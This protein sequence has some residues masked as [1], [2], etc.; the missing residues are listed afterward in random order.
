M[1]NSLASVLLTR[2]Q[3]SARL[4]ELRARDVWSLGAMALLIA[5]VELIGRASATEFWDL[6]MAVLL[7]S[8]LAACIELHRKCGLRWTRPVAAALS[9]GLRRLRVFEFEFGI[10]LRGRPPVPPAVPPALL[11]LPTTLVTLAAGALAWIAWG[12]VPF[13]AVAVQVSYVGYVAVMA[14]LWSAIVI[15]ALRMAVLPVLL[16]FDMLIVY[17]GLSRRQARPWAST[18]AALY[19][20]TLLVCGLMLPMWVGTLL[21]VLAIPLGLLLTWSPPWRR[22]ICLWKSPSSAVRS[23]SGRTFSTLT[24]VLCIPLALLVLVLFSLGGAALGLAESSGESWAMQFWFAPVSTALGAGGLWVFAPGAVLTYLLSGNH[25]LIAR[26]HDPEAPAPTTLHVQGPRDRA[27][28]V[29]IVQHVRSRGWQVRFAPARARRG[30]VC[31]RLEGDGSQP[32]GGLRPAFVVTEAEW[33]DPELWERMARRDVIQRRRI[34]VRG[35][36]KIFRRAASR[37]IED[38]SGY[39]VAPQYWFAPGVTRDGSAHEHTEVLQVVPPLYHR[40]LSHAARRHFLEICRA[41]EV[42]LIFVEDG[43]GF[44]GLRRVLRVLFEQYDIHGGRQKA[45]EIHFSG[46]AKVRVIFHDYELSKP[47]EKSK[48]QPPDYGDL[49]RARILHVFRDRGE[50]DEQ[51]LDPTDFD[52]LLSPV[53]SPAGAL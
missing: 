29:R 22:T 9:A 52:H 38:G 14:A 36:E 35:L 20:S 40:A 7:G 6:P 1:K 34:L 33:D 12:P 48:Y 32:A 37:Q 2:L 49:S 39:W 43:V 50:D 23:I 31:V 16:I 11:V 27:A 26:W 15:A 30:D 45:Q 13:R 41:L 24:E 28:Q 18:T 21:L 51:V 46:L 53:G 47:W 17:G 25:G 10:D 42:D 4:V 44:R 5:T 8:V 3:R 19:Y